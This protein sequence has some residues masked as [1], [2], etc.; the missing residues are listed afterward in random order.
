MSFQHP[1]VLFGLVVA[2]VPL[3]IHVYSRWFTDDFPRRAV[4]LL[5]LSRRARWKRLVEP[6][7][8]VAWWTIELILIV[9]A[10]A[11][12]VVRTPLFPRH[13]PPRSRTTI[14]LFDCSETMAG[15]DVDAARSWARSFFKEM[16]PDDRVAVYA[17][18]GDETLP[19]LVPPRSEPT[20]ARSSIVFLPRLRGQA[21]WPKAIEASSRKLAGVEGEC[22]VLVLTNDCRRIDDQISKRGRSGLAGQEM[23]R[24]WIA[25]LGGPRSC[26]FGAAEKERFG[27]ESVSSIEELLDRRGRGPAS[28]GVGG[29]VL[30]AA[31]ALVGL[32]LA[33]IRWS[34]RSPG[35]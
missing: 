5:N 29:L 17:V 31:L 32:Q 30:L 20:F 12:P 33:Y 22:D 4:A 2:L 21:D 26:T 3:A 35:S 9:V 18:L 10:L 15:N 19:L 27:L 14:V 16:Q 1:Y 24:V 13:D 11:G 28:R 6:W 7:F 8:L 34:R 25:N 23:P